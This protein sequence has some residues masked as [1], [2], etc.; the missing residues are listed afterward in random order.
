MRLEYS[1]ILSYCYFPVS[2]I[3]SSSNECIADPICKQRIAI[4]ME[5]NSTPNAFSNV[6]TRRLLLINF[7]KIQTSVSHHSARTCIQ[8]LGY[9]WIYSGVLMCNDTVP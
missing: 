8:Q 2:F 6:E 9:A 5:T 7:G 4:F 3:E 1:V